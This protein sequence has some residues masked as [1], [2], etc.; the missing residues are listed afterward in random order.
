[1]KVHDITTVEQ[2]PN[3]DHDRTKISIKMK[4]RLCETIKYGG[5]NA[6]IDWGK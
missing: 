2:L 3:I 1:M 5:I 4:D 6:D